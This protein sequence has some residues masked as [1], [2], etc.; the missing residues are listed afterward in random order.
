MSTALTVAAVVLAAYAMVAVALWRFQE[1]IVFQPPRFPES[2]DAMDVEWLSFSSS[3]GTALF[4]FVVGDPA[5][6]Q[7]VLAFH[8]NAVV[9]RA[10][11]PWAREVAGR[12]G[13]CI[14]LAEYRGYDGLKSSPTYAGTQLDAEAALDAASAHIGVDAKD[15]FIYGHSLGSAVATELAAKRK[16]KAL[17]LQSPFTSARAM[18]SRWPVVGFRVGWSLVSRVHFDTLKLVA[19]LE[20][21]V[22][23]AH[24]E[25]DMVVPVWMGKAIFAAARVP[26]KLLI[27]RSAGHNDVAE[28]GGQAYW[29]WVAEI[30]S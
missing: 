1:R 19:D 28:V 13:I 15:F 16:G 12:I 2:P 27:V 8:G 17:I 4:A 9:A 23:V 3:D 30:V 26:G 29:R 24:G 11:I 10:V 14:V 22:H 7:V 5:S 25:R 18:V 6:R 21:P 20:I